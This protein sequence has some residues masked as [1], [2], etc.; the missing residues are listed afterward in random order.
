MQI[1][2]ANL[3]ILLVAYAEHSTV[4]VAVVYLKTGFDRQT[5]RRRRPHCVQ[6]FLVQRKRHHSNA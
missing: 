6:I 5:V 1:W 2:T 3:S 4:A